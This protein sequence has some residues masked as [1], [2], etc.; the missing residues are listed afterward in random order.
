MRMMTR[1]MATMITMRLDDGSF[2]DNLIVESDL[3]NAVSW[4]SQKGRAP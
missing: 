4:V 1:M 3:S 2:G